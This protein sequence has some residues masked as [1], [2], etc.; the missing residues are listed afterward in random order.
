MLNPDL[1]YPFQLNIADTDTAEKLAHTL[2][3]IGESEQRILIHNAGM[4]VRRDFE[5]FTLEEIERLTT[6]NFLSP[7]KI[8]QSLI[9]WLQKAQCGHTVYIGSMA[10]FQGSRKY[11]GLSAYSASKSAG[12]SLMESLAAEFS[13]TNLY[14]NTLALG[15]VRTGML[16]AAFPGQQGLEAGLIAD[17]IVE[18]AL[19][20]W[21]FYNGKVLPLSTGD[22]VLNG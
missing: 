6:V 21:R 1:Y 19:N 3:S 20:G 7:F 15:A 12:S 13:G 16:D 9:P 22:P 14:F 4:L 18:F 8:T 2:G 10:G 5:Q 17:Y 11:A